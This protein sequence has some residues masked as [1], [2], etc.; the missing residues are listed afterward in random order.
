MLGGFGVLGIAG[1]VLGECFDPTI[2]N[3]CA[4][5]PAHLLGLHCTPCSAL[6]QSH[7]LLGCSIRKATLQASCID[8]HT[9]RLHVMRCRSLDLRIEADA[10]KRSPHND[11]CTLVNPA[12]KRHLRHVTPGA[13]TPDL[14]RY[15]C[16][17]LPRHLR[18][19]VQAVPFGVAPGV[20]PGSDAYKAAPQESLGAEAAAAAETAAVAGANGR[21]QK[22][23][24][25]KQGEKA[26]RVVKQGDAHR[27][28]GSAQGSSTLPASA[29]AG[30]AATGSSGSSS[31]S[32]QPG[33][34]HSYSLHK[35]VR[36]KRGKAG[37]A[38]VARGDPTT[39]T[40]HTY[41]VLR[42][43]EELQATAAAYHTASRNGAPYQWPDAPWNVA[44][45][46][47]RR[48]LDGGWA[49]NLMAAHS[50][51]AVAWCN[52]CGTV[53]LIDMQHCWHALY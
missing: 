51:T 38:A 24:K 48:E 4:A 46:D 28:G 5:A 34:S 13:A 9:P 3:A 43:T 8:S 21:G 33:T 15:G 1:A 44:V 41:G 7:T 10:H 20:G 19:G 42:P 11:K 22:H 45:G 50:H 29:S 18:D 47:P 39:Y 32:S 31:V 2:D 36:Q 27:K 35:M 23:G 30:A 25:Q 52:V 26:G 37:Q 12:G 40:I 17:T 53:K 16:D 6:L 14:R 49:W